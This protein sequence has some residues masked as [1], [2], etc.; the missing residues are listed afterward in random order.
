[1]A[2]GSLYRDHC[3][4][5]MYQSAKIFDTRVRSQTPRH[6]CESSQDVLSKSNK[7]KLTPQKRTCTGFGPGLHGKSPQARHYSS[8]QAKGSTAEQDWHCLHPSREPTP[9]QDAAPGKLHS[10]FGSPQEGQVTSSSDGRSLVSSRCCLPVVALRGL[11][12]TPALQACHMLAS[13]FVAARHLGADSCGC[14]ILETAVMRETRTGSI[15][16]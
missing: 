10:I 3:I 14:C 9:N 5:F 15:L 8:L 12:R 2:G 11:T 7:A 13:P 4:D 16:V 6:K 1:M